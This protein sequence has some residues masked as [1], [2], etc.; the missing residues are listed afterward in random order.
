MTAEM[1]EIESLYQNESAI[2][3]AD[4]CGLIKFSSRVD[5]KVLKNESDTIA[6]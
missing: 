6:Y 5:H 3:L 2:V 4:K 1:E